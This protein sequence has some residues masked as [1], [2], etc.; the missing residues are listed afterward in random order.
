M[1][2]G[3]VL[4]REE[5]GGLV[6]N[7]LIG[8]FVGIGYYCEIIVVCDGDVV[9]IGSNGVKLVVVIVLWGVGY[10]VDNCLG[11]GFGGFFVFVC[12]DGG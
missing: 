4:V 9:F 12:D 1:G 5:E 7:C 8:W 6:D 2:I 11:L 10:V 3:C